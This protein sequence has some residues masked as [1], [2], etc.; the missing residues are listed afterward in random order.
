MQLLEEIG[1]DSG[2]VTGTEIL[3]TLSPGLAGI[4]QDS[5]GCTGAI[6][7]QLSISFTLRAQTAMHLVLRVIRTDGHSTMIAI[8][9]VTL[10]VEQERLLLGNR[11]LLGV[12]LEQIEG[13]CVGML[14]VDC[15]LLES[16]PSI[17]RMF[18][19]DSKLLVGQS[20]CDMSGL[21][22]TQGGSPSFSQIR[23]SVSRG[24]LFHQEIELRH[25]SGKVLWGDLVVSPTVDAQGA[26]IGY[27]TVMR[28]VSEQHEVKEQLLTDAQTDP[29][30][31]VLNRRGLELNIARIARTA[32]LPG[33]QMCWIAIDIDHFKVINDTYGHES[34]DAVLQR[35][36]S[37]IKTGARQ[38]DIVARLG[39]EE[40]VVLLPGASLKAAMATAERMRVSIEAQLLSVNDITFRVTASFGVALQS[41]FTHWEAAL[42]AAD[43]AMYSAKSSGRNKV[44]AAASD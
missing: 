36:A 42:K 17:D 26:T 19:L 27:V 10:S 34:G 8:D 37:L 20:L 11:Q 25:T 4:W 23:E 6:R 14:N 5:A 38:G 33:N 22:R 1:I 39:G 21:Q 24:G 30:T 32:S 43:E 28:N 40:F 29:L 15:R 2:A 12:M 7:L 41:G 3:N 13:Y 16:N 31:G 35:I 44:V 9:G 18:G